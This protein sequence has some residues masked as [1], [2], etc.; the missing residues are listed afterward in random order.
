MLPLRLHALLSS[1]EPGSPCPLGFQPG[2]TVFAGEI[3]YVLVPDSL[4][5][6]Q[7]YET[8]PSPV[9]ILSGKTV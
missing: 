4:A 8:L 9:L 1:F 3:V 2:R 6:A 7:L 5:L